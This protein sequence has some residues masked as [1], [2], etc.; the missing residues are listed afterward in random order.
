MENNNELENFL[1]HKLS[2]DELDLQVPKL[3][4]T[5]R[6]KIATRKKTTGEIEDFFSL[7]AAFLNF[8]IKLYHAVLATIIIGGIILFFTKEDKNNNNETYSSQYVSNIA[9]V[10]SSTV[11]SSICT[12]GLNKEQSYGNGA[13]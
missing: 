13:N 11:L 8:K 10:K 1:S 7:V 3:S 4:E 5:A 12:F 9:S 6:K 2:V